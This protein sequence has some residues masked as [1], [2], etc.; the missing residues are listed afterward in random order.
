[1]SYQL[2]GIYT[3]IVDIIGCLPRFFGWV[4]SDLQHE[5]FNFHIFPKF[6]I[7]DLSFFKPMKKME[8]QQ[9]LETQLF[10]HGF[11]QSKFFV[12]IMKIHN[13]QI[14]IH[15]F[16]VLN[17]YLSS[18]SLQTL[19]CNIR[20]ATIEVA[21]PRRNP[22]FFWHALIFYNGFF[23]TSI[24]LSSYFYVVYDVHWMLLLT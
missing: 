21:F 20:K 8:Y 7:I 6:S 24:L 13:F 9:E 14:R 16:N 1:M 4:S 3:I 22:W 18:Y 5:F 23:W 12:A 19:Y 11:H 17:L 10:L 15:L 2:I